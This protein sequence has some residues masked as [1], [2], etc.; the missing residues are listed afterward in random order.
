MTHI[1][2]NDFKKEMLNGPVF[3]KQVENIEAGK[4]ATCGKDVNENDFTDSLSRK[5]FNISGMCQACQNEV[6][7]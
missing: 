2:D 6:F 3:T 1:K 5:E 7:G 4:C